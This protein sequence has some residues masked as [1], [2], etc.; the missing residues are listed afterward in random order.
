MSSCT[1]RTG[2]GGAA[3][4]P[5][6]E[7]ARK[8]QVEDIGAGA[9]KVDCVTD[10]THPACSRP[11][12]HPPAWASCVLRDR[13]KGM[14][15][16]SLTK[17]FPISTLDLQRALTRSGHVCSPAACLKVLL[18]LLRTRY[19]FRL[20]ALC[21][22]PRCSLAG[23]K[24]GHNTKGSVNSRTHT[25]STPA[26]H[27]QNPDQQKGEGRLTHVRP[28]Q[29]QALV[30]AKVLEGAGAAERVM[31]ESDRRG[32]EGGFQVLSR[33]RNI[34]PIHPGRCASRCADCS[35]ESGRAS[36]Q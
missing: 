4:S 6:A 27:T 26:R 33:W 35:W 12:R 5:V 31:Q 1:G 17:G 21:A 30:Q 8:A 32:S 14:C 15:T 7:K 13:E 29:V 11:W 10:S 24:I 19:A 28:S 23:K 22:Q 9:N 18:P 25:R 2:A 16:S 36:M 34:Q 3:A 20:L